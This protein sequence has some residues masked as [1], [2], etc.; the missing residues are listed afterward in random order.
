MTTAIYDVAIAATVTGLI[1]VI[2]EHPG[3]AI[4]R[5]QKIFANDTRHDVESMEIRWHKKVNTGQH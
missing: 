3:E 4:E 2:A 5:A 1:R